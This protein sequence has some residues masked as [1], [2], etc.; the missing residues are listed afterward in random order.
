[1]GARRKSVLAGAAVAVVV[2]AAMT[3]G[4]YACSGPGPEPQPPP[5]ATTPPPPV[6]SSPTRQGVSPFTGLRAEPAPV[7][8]VKIDNVRPARPH[9][10]LGAADIVYVEQVE[11]GQSRLLAVYSSQLPRTVG[12]VRSARES[13]LELLRQFGRPALAYSGEQSALRPLI[14]AAPL[15]ALTPSDVPRAYFRGQDRPAPHNL[16]VRPERALAAVPKADKAKDIG[17]RFGAAP[18]GG[19]QVN[20]HTVRYPAARFTFTWSDSARRW[21]VAM[22]GA[23]ARTTDGGQ[24]AARTVVVQNVDVRPSRFRDRGGN[25]TPYTETVGS[26]TALVLRDGRSHDARW[27]RPAATG[28]TTFTTPAGQP[29]TF[30]TGQVWVV[31]IGR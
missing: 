21:L 19:R 12:P 17:F 14:D 27:N 4:L 10:G 25:V 11:A 29:L 26:G 24:A 22:D 3:A 18:A 5:S 28:G 2:S 23:P 7:L 1:M 20:E 6:P 30:A 8:T 16:Y 15:F 13:D 31:L 9:T